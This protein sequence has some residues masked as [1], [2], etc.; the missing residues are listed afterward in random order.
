MTPIHWFEAGAE[1][2]GL[3]LLA[4]EVYLGHEMEKLTPGMEFVREMQFLYAMKDYKGCYILG[5]LHEGDS[6]ETVQLLVD[7]LGPAAIE[8][9]VQ[10]TWAQIA[11]QATASILRWRERTA[12][13]AMQ[14]RRWQLVLGTLL[15]LCGPVIH[16][17]ELN[18]HSPL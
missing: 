3:I 1:I 15:L 8:Q 14:R 5:R 6:I 10:T 4:R 9:G 13:A 16:I 17:W 7:E 18:N 12:P 11:P 2:A